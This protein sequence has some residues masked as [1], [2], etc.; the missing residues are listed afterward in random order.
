MAGAASHNSSTGRRNMLESPPVFTQTTAYHNSPSPQ[1]PNWG[2]T[3]RGWVE[4][5][6]ELAIRSTAHPGPGTTGSSS[7]A[8]MPGSSHWSNI[9]DPS[10]AEFTPLQPAPLEG[11]SLESPADSSV[12]PQSESPTGTEQSPACVCS[13]E[14]REEERNSYH[15]ASQIHAHKVLNLLHLIEKV[16]QNDKTAASNYAHHIVGS[17]IIELDELKQLTDCYIFDNLALQSF[18]QKLY[19][20]DASD[21]SALQDEYGTLANAYATISQILAG[22]SESWWS[23]WLEMLEPASDPIL[24]YGTDTVPVLPTDPQRNFNVAVGSVA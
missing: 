7:M 18:A 24:W 4:L 1:S 17:A 2:I 22:E 11:E 16:E 14:Q 8:P 15:E 10:A 23:H 20:N 12:I 6:L 21:T 9:F 19:G 5:N 3:N 13:P